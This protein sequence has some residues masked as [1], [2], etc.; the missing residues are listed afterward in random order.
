MKLLESVIAI[1]EARRDDLTYTEKKVKDQLQRVTVALN[2]AESA[3]MSR[4]AKRYE[5]LEKSLAKMKEQRDRLNETLKDKTSELFAV[6]DVVVTRVVETA[7]FTLTLAKE[8]KSAEPIIK[9]DYEAIA[10]ALIKILPDDLQSKVDEITALY[11]TITPPK[12]PPKK[13]SVS[14][15]TEGILTTL[16]GITAALIS[17]AKSLAKWSVKYDQKLDSLEDKF[18]EIKSKK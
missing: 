13:L 14:P 18:K 5:R 3:T 16:K 9:K 8:V 6:E 10:A 11:T 4:L 12:D 7:S 15:I 1:T 17:R 2:G